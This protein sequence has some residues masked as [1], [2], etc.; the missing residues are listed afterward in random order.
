[1]PRLDF[2]KQFARQLKNREILPSANSWEKLQGKL[3]REEKKKTPL[4]LWV[5][6]AASLVGAI[7]VLN[8]MYNDP[9]T[10]VPERIV[11]IEVKGPEETQKVDQEEIPQLAFE[12]PNVSQEKESQPE[13]SGKTSRSEGPEA[14]AW[15]TQPSVVGTKIGDATLASEEIPEDGEVSDAEI[16]ALLAKAIA[17]VSKKM[18]EAE[19]ITDAQIDV[20]L[21]EARAEVKKEKVLYQTATFNAEDLLLEVETELEHSFREQVFEI[22]KDGLRKTRNAVVNLNE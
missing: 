16:D 13:V 20:L 3:E 2:E 19:E 4:Y 18:P 21:A 8:F 7:L 22:V 1:M 5:G 17:E 15:E 10:E 9:V 6:M 14:S 11:E 12:E